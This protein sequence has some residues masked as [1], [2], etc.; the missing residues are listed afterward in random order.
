MSGIV[1]ELAANRV[2]R[3][4]DGAACHGQGYLEVDPF[5]FGI[6]RQ[7][8][9]SGLVEG[10]VHSVRQDPF[11]RSG[12]DHAAGGNRFGF[13]RPPISGISDLDVFG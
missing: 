7:A 12:E 5:L 4:G 2:V 1:R 10:L 9:D 13:A 8:V 11:M 6:S 3:H